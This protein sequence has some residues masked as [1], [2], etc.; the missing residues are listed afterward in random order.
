MEKQQLLKEIRAAYG[1]DTVQLLEDLKNTQVS[2]RPVRNVASG[3]ALVSIGDVSKTY[4][5]GKTTVNALNGVSLEIK[6]GEIVALTGPSGSG[7][8]TLL[9]LMAGL[10]HPTEGTVTVADTRVDLLKGDQ[11]STYRAEKLGFV[12]QFF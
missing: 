4:K 11:M 9:H 7:K 1:E 2:V 6:K 5:L 12:F 8:S 10:D 3:P